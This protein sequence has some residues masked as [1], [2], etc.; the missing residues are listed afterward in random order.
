MKRI[1]L[2]WRY[3]SSAHSVGHLAK[4]EASRYA[5]TG[6]YLFA[7]RTRDRT[8][9]NASLECLSEDLKRSIPAIRQRQ[10]LDVGLWIAFGDAGCHCIRDRMR[11]RAV[12]EGIWSDNDAGT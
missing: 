6:R 12:A 5:D 2:G 8:M 11:R 9:I 10:Q 1:A 7:S 4:A 3:Q